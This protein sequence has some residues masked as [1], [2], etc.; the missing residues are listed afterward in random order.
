MRRCCYEERQE[1]MV[2]LELGQFSKSCPKGVVQKERG[3]SYT[4]KMTR[5][6]KGVGRNNPGLFL[7]SHLPMSLLCILLA[8]PAKAREQGH[9]ENVVPCDSEH[10]G[11]RKGWG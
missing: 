6:R 7:S 5:G 11:A 2:L 1:Q 10:R 8:K 4:E 9:L 3:W